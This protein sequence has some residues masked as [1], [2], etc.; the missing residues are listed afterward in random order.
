MR[1]VTAVL[2]ALLIMC[3]AIVNCAAAQKKVR[4]TMTL[5]GDVQYQKMAEEIVALHQK[6]FP[7]VEVDVML[8]PFSE[9]SKKLS[10]MNAAGSSPDVAWLASEMTTVFMD[11]GSLL[12]ISAIEKDKEFDINDIFPSTISH[13]RKGK[14]LYGVSTNAAPGIIFFNKTLFKEKGLKTPLELAKEGNWTYDKMLSSAKAITDH[15]RG[16]FGVRLARDW[17][18][19]PDTLVDLFWAYGAD[20]L[21]K[22]N[23]KFELNSPKGAA[24]LQYFS[25]LMFEFKVHPKPGEQTSFE[26]GKVAM[27]RDKFGY[28]R[29]LANANF[30]WDIAPLPLGP[31]P[32]APIW[33]G[34]SCYSVFKDTKHPR[35]A[36]E[37][38]KTI[39]SKQGQ[40]IATRLIPPSRKS[41]QQSDVFLKAQSLPTVEAIKISIIDKLSGPSQPFITPQNWPLIEAGIQSGLDVLYSG[42]ASV[43]S[44]L[45]KMGKE[46]EPLLK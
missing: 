11:S 26:S 27:Y 20:I 19:W 29:K 45:E 33:V 12:D 38:V 21:S 36:M 3:F 8:I 17:K 13:L 31:N 10:I 23:K 14:K 22:D 9:Y 37:L 24:A 30:D 6:K 28:V 5:W 46:V 35:E 34:A 32:K 40:T 44:A 39:T 7:N 16:V 1:K 18:S 4:L 42:N 2:L 25:D 43:K 41:V 15:S